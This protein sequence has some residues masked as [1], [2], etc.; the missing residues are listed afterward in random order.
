M[1][2]KHSKLVGMIREIPMGSSRKTASES[3]KNY[4]KVSDDNFC[5]KTEFEV[6]YSKLSKSRRKISLFTA[7]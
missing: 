7:T 5:K 2:A 3:R 1:A 4:A 6:E